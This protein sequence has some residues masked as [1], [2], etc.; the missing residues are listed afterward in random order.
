M[1]SKRNGLSRFLQ[2]CLA[3]GLFHN[4]AGFPLTGVLWRCP[5]VFADRL[6]LLAAMASR[7]LPSGFQGARGD[8]QR[9]TFGPST[10][11][12]APC[13]ASG[14]RRPQGGQGPIHAVWVGRAESRR[15]Q[16]SWERNRARS[17]IHGGAANPPQN[18]RAGG[19]SIP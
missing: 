6:P 9:L 19:S 16:T 8:H 2:A 15:H 17:I 12:P 4:G 10:S 7:W 13:R 5:Q 18:V 1:G 3:E 14:R 11:H